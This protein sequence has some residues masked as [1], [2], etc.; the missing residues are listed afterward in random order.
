[1]ENLELGINITIN[2]NVN[3]AANQAARA[4]GNASNAV[5][6]LK[7]SSEGSL[8]SL[9]AIQSSLFV[10]TKFATT[11][12][13][14]GFGIVGG[15]VG[16]FTAGVKSAGEFEK[17]LAFL[18][19]ATG[20]SFTFAKQEVNRLATSTDLSTQSIVDMSRRL[21]GVG[22]TADQVF[23]KVKGAQN[24]GI[25]NIAAAIS[26]LSS[27]ER[28]RALASIANI[29][30]DLSSVNRLLNTTVP[31][32]IKDAFSSAANDAEKFNIVLGF[33]DQRFGGIFGPEGLGGSFV[34][35]ATRAFQNLQDLINRA[36]LPALE[37]LTPV[38]QTLG[39]ELTKLK[40]DEKFIAALN[41]TF[42]SLAKIASSVLKIVVQIGL[43]L[44]K[45]IA[46]FPNFTTGI[47][48]TT[49]FGGALLGVFGLIIFGASSVAL[50]GLS[51]GKLTTGLAAASS[52]TGLFALNLKILQ[53]ATNPASIALLGLA[54]GGI[55]GLLLSINELPHFM[56]RFGQGA[57]MLGVTLGTII[58]SLILIVSLISGIVGAVAGFAL[59]GIPGAI[60]GA[61]GG[62]G[63]T[64]AGLSGLTDSG[65]QL[66]KNTLPVQ[67]ETSSMTRVSGESSMNSSL[68]DLVDSFQ[69]MRQDLNKLGNRPIDINNNVMLDGKVVSNTVNQINKTET[70]RLGFI[71][72][73]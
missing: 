16:A 61:L 56:D 9:L 54:L 36:F 58:N 63:L 27:I 26:S 30:Q 70:E 17:S 45:F 34:F 19:V 67:Q 37:S 69:E 31:Q 40:D 50:L 65:E 60:A 66:Q 51:V 3:Q 18:R 48:L 59:G 64:F 32:S 2:G 39:A 41:K 46:A 44:V 29:F 12:A 42:V 6:R 10:I 33:L 23:K 21:L 71:L 68:L 7:R 20:K 14:L 28:P 53:A 62:F 49:L 22:L 57:K 47:V 1:V 24:S 72:P 25:V 5:D 13:S 73:P 52:A 11:F 15:I 43:G 4:L 8:G 55:L 35:I 38:F